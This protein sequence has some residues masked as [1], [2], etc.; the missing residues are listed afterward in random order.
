MLITSEKNTKKRGLFSLKTVCS[1]I[2]NTYLLAL[3]YYCKSRHFFRFLLPF[4]HNNFIC[5]KRNE[6]LHTLKA[7]L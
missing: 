2:F 7:K 5:N 4:I 1:A 3:V 6:K